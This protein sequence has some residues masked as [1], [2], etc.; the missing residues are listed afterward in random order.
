MGEVARR[1]STTN[2][3]GGEERDERRGRR[4]RA[5]SDSGEKRT[6][7]G[8]HDIWFRRDERLN[9]AISDSGET[10]GGKLE[11]LL[12]LGE[13]PTK[14]EREEGGWERGA[15][16]REERRGAYERGENEGVRMK[17]L[18]ARLL[19]YKP[20]ATSFQIKKKSP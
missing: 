10:N 3:D 19:F 12:L 14:V 6:N 2:D 17:T 1:R 7:D 5:I 9:K 13:D 16:E 4:E 11:F 8:F 15:Y 18:V 20:N